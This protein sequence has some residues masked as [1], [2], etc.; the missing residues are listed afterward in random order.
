MYRK[1]DDTSLEKLLE[2]GIDEFAEHGLDKTVMSDIAKQ[3]QMEP[4]SFTAFL[5][6]LQM[7]SGRLSWKNI[8][9]V[10]RQK[11]KKLS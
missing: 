3:I 7:K 2:A 8:S 1:L 6:K 4:W 11:F 10:T 9:M 5:M